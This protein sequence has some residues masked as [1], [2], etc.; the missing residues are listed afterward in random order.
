MSFVSR[1]WALTSDKP[2]THMKPCQHQD[3]HAIRYRYT[4]YQTY[5]HTNT[6]YVYCNRSWQHHVCCWAR[7]SLRHCIHCIYCILRGISLHERQ[8]TADS[9]LAAATGHAP[10]CAFWT[11][12]QHSMFFAEDS[13]PVVAVTGP[14]QDVS[15]STRSKKKS[16]ITPKWSNE[17]SYTDSMVTMVPGR[18][19]LGSSIT[20][21]DIATRYPCSSP[22][23]SRLAD[24][25]YVGHE[26]QSSSP[27]SW[28]VKRMHWPP[29]CWWPRHRRM[30]KLLVWGHIASIGPDCDSTLVCCPACL[31]TSYSMDPLFASIIYEMTGI[32]GLLGSNVLHS[33]NFSKTLQPAGEDH[34]LVHTMWWR[35]ILHSQTAYA[36]CKVQT[37]TAVAGIFQKKC[38]TQTLRQYCKPM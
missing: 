11:V 14:G 29:M 37:W 31:T 9:C 21:W 23:A 4:C 8:P 28:F 26:L 33:K 6:I 38:S 10:L 17:E 15:K 27:V 35:I 36:A 7:L 34:K 24:K 12:H 13:V 32:T 25:P 22:T 2:S 3:I 30:P 18:I 5:Y 16:A 19:C 20:V 1:T